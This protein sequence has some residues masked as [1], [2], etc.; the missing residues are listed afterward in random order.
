MQY[1]KEKDNS[2]HKIRSTSSNATKTTTTKITTINCNK[3]KS[4]VICATNVDSNIKDIKCS[5]SY[6]DNKNDKRILE[7]SQVD[8]VK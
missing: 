7:K 8:V 1:N 5:K 4:N 2:V 6:H 3:K